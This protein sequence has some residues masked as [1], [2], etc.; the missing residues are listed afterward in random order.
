RNHGGGWDMM[1]LSNAMTL[2][3]N[4]IKNNF[5]HN[6]C[7]TC[8]SFQGSTLEE[9]ITIFNHKFVY[10]SRKWLYTAVTKA[11][12]LKQVY[13]LRLRGERREREGNDTILC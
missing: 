12:N 2:P 10:V 1:T 8:H 6:Y 7:K 11:T 13:F 9:S 4:L 3:I 5:A